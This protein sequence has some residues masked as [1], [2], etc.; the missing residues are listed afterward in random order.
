MNKK[1]QLSLWQ[2]IASAVVIF[3]LGFVVS[4]RLSVGVFWPQP[5]QGRPDFTSL[6]SVYDTLERKFD[7]HLSNAQ[8]LDGAKAGLVSAAGDPYTTYLTAS[9]AKSLGDQLAGTLSGIGI[10]I[11][12]KGG[13][14]TVIAPV[15]D[16]PAAKAGLRAGDLIA[17]IDGQ[18]ASTL[19]LDQA[20]AKIRGT[21]GTTVKLVVVRGSADPVTYTI[22]RANI[23]VPSVTWQVRSDGL[24]Y[25]K[26]SQ[27][28]TDTGDLVTKAATALVAA[29]V[30]GVIVDLRDNPGGYLDQAV[31]VA[32]QFLPGGQV[33]VSERH[34]SATI[35]QS[36]SSGGGL[37]V[38]QP[39]VVL[40]NGGSA[41]AAEILAGALQD[42]HA[43]KL[44]GV[45]TFGKGSVQDITT[46]GGGA[47]LKIT[48]AHW[49]T[50]DGQNIDKAGIKP[51]QVVAL[52]QS[53]YDHSLDP[54]LDAA[55][56][57]LK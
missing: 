57:A 45:T 56:A 36:K 13:N 55:V 9:D 4:S 16:T 50:P 24:G 39:T 29:H 23:T 28:S 51:D 44:I 21:A 7:G 33:V 32:S 35:D 52:S 38:G 8:L 31:A 49:Y 46:L 14:L 20:V 3:G 34:G 19:T 41:S 12:L 48:I 30:R 15:A 1:L 26:I 18:D 40:V 37:L 2:A 6:N 42:H 5:T 17:S 53:D 10:E 25:I 54:Q 22:T 47:E 43:A 11:G 27:F